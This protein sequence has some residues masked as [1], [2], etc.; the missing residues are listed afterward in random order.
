MKNNKTRFVLS[1]AAASNHRHNEDNPIGFPARLDEVIA[2]F[3]CR[4]N[5]QRSDFSPYPGNDKFAVPGEVIKAAYPPDLNNNLLEKRLSGTSAATAML[6]GI[7]GLVI[8]YAKLKSNTAQSIS[9][10]DRLWHTQG[11]KSVFLGCMT[12]NHNHAPG[13]YFV[14]K[15]W[16]LLSTK[17]SDLDVSKKIMWALWNTL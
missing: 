17:H 5:G 7:A 3:S 1:F 12:T 6:A 8:E 14:V 11:M 2:A 10:S 4:Y 15:P 16:L 9:I 13:D